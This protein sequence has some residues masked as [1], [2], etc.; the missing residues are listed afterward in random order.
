MSQIKK[1]NLARSPTARLL[2]PGEQIQYKLPADMYNVSYV[3]VN[4]R[5]NASSWLKPA[6]L[7]TSCGSVYLTNSSKAPVQVKKA[8]HL[9]DIR[10]TCEF[11]NFTD[12]PPTAKYHDDQFQFMNLAT[13]KEKPDK[14]LHLLRVDPDNVLSP[15]DKQIFHELHRKYARVFSLHN[16]AS[17]MVSLD[18]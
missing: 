7:E 11:Q 18:L 10:D 3:A 13:V 14:Y 6:V 15:E 2:L 1:Y 16:Q 9:A 5:P 4:P 17:T 12:P 8:E